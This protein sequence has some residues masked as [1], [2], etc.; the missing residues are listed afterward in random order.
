MAP[1]G[2]AMAAGQYLAATAAASCCWPLTRLSVAAV[3]SSATVEMVR[4]HRT[5]EVTVRTDRAAQVAAAADKSL[6]TQ[7]RFREL[8]SAPLVASVAWPSKTP[9]RKRTWLTPV[10]LAHPVAAAQFGLLALER[11]R[12]TRDPTLAHHRMQQALMLQVSQRMSSGSLAVATQHSRD[13]PHRLRSVVRATTVPS[14]LQ[15][16]APRTW[17]RRRR[18]S[19]SPFR[20]SML[21]P[22]ASPSKSW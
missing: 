1:A 11:T 5:S 2:L 21:L 4:H 10:Q 14:G 12:R 15:S 3:R 17:I 13:S 8:S 6:F 19:Q 20:L 9:H 7:S 18:L 16:W 22:A